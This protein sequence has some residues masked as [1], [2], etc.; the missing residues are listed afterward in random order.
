MAKAILNILQYSMN[1]KKSHSSMP[2]A[3]DRRRKLFAQN[4]GIFSSSRCHRLRNSKRCKWV[5]VVKR[6]NICMT[7]AKIW[8]HGF[9]IKV[10]I[11][12]LITEDRLMLC[13]AG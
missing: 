13:Y 6:K 4:S 5:H 1:I 11:F 10:Y 9:T 3:Q 8:A 7:H 12:Q 2:R